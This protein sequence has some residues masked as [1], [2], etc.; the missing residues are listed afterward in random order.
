MPDDPR[1][2]ARLERIYVILVAVHCFAVGFG[3]LF[4]PRFSLQLAG[5][6]DVELLF[7][8]RQGG[9]FH[10]VVAAGYLVEYSRHRTITLMLIAKPFAF[11]FLM[12]L[13]AFTDV[14]WAVPISGVGDGAMGLIAWLLHR[15][16]HSSPTP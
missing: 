16:V 7:F 9:A 6:G 5:W 13:W 14:P 4:L 12:T 1:G 8:V 3:L 15:Q 11:V 2:L 10:L